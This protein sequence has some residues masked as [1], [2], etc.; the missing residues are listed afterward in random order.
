MDEFGLP[1]MKVLL[2]A[3]DGE[4]GP[5]PYAPHNHRPDSV[6]YTGTHDNNTVCGW[7]A[8]DSDQKARSLVSEYTGREVNDVNVSEVFANMALSSTSGLAILPMQDILSLGASARMNIPGVAA[9][10]WVWRM[11]NDQF[12][13]LHE[14]DSGIRMRYKRLNRI[15]GR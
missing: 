13:S 5:N 10:N 2:F 1:G 3:F 6:V 15:Y 8:N 9:G 4:S 12:E 11:T 14:A 7:W